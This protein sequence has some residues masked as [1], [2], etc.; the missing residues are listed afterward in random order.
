MFPQYVSGRLHRS[1]IYYRNIN[2]GFSLTGSRADEET[3]LISSLLPGD[4]IPLGYLTLDFVE[5]ITRVKDTRHSI[6]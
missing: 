4:I 3:T 5:E 6:F 1:I 2:E